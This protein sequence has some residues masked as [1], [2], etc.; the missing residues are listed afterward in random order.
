MNRSRLLTLTVLV[1]LSLASLIPSERTH[2]LPLDGGELPSGPGVD[3]TMLVDAIPNWYYEGDQS[4]DEVGYSLGTAGDVN[5][6]G[7]DDVIVGAAQDTVSV[8]REG[9]AYVFYGS[10]AGLSTLPDWTVGSGQKGSRFGAAVGTAGNVNGDDYDDVIVGAYGY[11]VD[12]GQVGAVFVFLGSEDGLSTTP[13]WTL[14]GDQKDAHL[15][16]S[17]GTAGDVNDDG[18]SDV[19]VGE[20]WYSDGLVD[21]AGR[22]LVFY[23]SDSGLG[24][25]PD[26]TAEGDSA[27]AGFGSSVATAGDVDNDGYD[28]VIVGAPYAENGGTVEGAAYVFYGSAA[29]LLASPHWTAYGQQAD[30]SFGASVSTAGRVNGD[31]YADIIVGAPLFDQVRA[32]DGAVF[33]YYGGGSGPGTTHN[34]MA[35]GNQADS[36]FGISAA[37]AGDVDDDGYEDV[38]VGAYLDTTDQNLEGSAYIFYGSST[39]LRGAAG[40][41]AEGDKAETQFG[42]AVGTAGSVNNDDIADVL[43]GAPNY[44]NVTDLRG[45]AFGFYGP[46][47]AEY[48]VYAHCA[49]LPLVQSASP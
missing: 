1:S 15:G 14:V 44:R 12:Q 43:V 4:G 33:V 27:A 45:R 35:Y 13:D 47:E 10:P 26:W 38:I 18:Y 34:W 21:N 17:V 8:D 49:Y 11:K 16:A 31:D 41:A 25:D 3:G 36:G 20:R 42:Y 19:I 40:W 32:N 5:G 39:G 6:D 24:S 48:P 7:H 9:V 23:G 29:G 2:S 46:L 30:S 37:A 28:D 22:V